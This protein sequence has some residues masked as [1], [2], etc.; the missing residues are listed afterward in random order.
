MFKF[1]ISLKLLELSINNCS[2]YTKLFFLIPVLKLIMNYIYESYNIKLRNR[3]DD[4]IQ[5]V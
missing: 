5:I 4:K 3:L 2:D 1:L